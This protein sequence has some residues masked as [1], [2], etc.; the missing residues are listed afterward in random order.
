MG[1]NGRNFNWRYIVDG[2]ADRGVKMV[3][4]GEA[5]RRHGAI[6]VKCLNPECGREAAVPTAFLREAVRPRAQCTLPFLALSELLK[7]SVCGWTNPSIQP[8]WG[9]PPKNGRNSARRR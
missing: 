3:M 9:E 8:D 7:C 4:L 5:L 1:Y 6:R 2:A